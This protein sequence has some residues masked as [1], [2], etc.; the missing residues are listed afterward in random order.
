MANAQKMIEERKKALL[1]LKTNGPASTAPP[2]MSATA[3]SS[4]PLAGKIPP[5]IP[6]PPSTTAEKDNATYEKAMKIAQLQVSVEEGKL[7]ILSS[8]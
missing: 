4:L 7:M 3:A 6:T 8:R 5:L 2:V 1:A